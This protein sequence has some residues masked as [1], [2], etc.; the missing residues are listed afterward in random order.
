[1][2]AAK[3]DGTAW[4][5]GQHGAT[6][7]TTPTEIP[8]LTDVTAFAQNNNGTD[9]A[10]LADGTVRS[11]GPSFEYQLENGSDCIPGSDPNTCYQDTPVPVTGLSS[12]TA[13]SGGNAAGYALRS[14]GTVWA[15]GGGNGGVLGDGGMYSYRGVPVRVTGHSGV[16]GLG[17]YGYTIAN[18]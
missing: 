12:V 6:Q 13:I 10:L 1:M 18:P 2:L 15:W 4:R 17:D 14:D 11:W 9:Y 16:T 7:D 8:G 3:S 5:W